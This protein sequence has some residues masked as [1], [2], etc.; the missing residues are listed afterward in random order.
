[1][2]SEEFLSAMGEI[3]EK[4]TSGAASAYYGPANPAGHEV[5]R[6]LLIAAVIILGLCAAMAGSLFLAS[7]AGLLPADRP[8][9]SGETSEAVTYPSDSTD[10][11][12]DFN[13]LFTWR[14]PVD[15]IRYVWCREWAGTFVLFLNNDGTFSQSSGYAASNLEWGTWKKED[16]I[17]TLT[18]KEYTTMKGTKRQNVYRFAEEDD[19][20]LTF[21]SEGSD[22]FGYVSVEDGDKFFP[23]GG[24]GSL[25]SSEEINALREQSR[26]EFRAVIEKNGGRYTAEDGKTEKL[27]KTSGIHFLDD[28]TDYTFHDRTPAIAESSTDFRLIIFH[29]GERTT[30]LFYLKDG[31]VRSLVG[32]IVYPYS[33]DIWDYDRNGRNDLVIRYLDRDY[34]WIITVVDLND[35]SLKT[36]QTSDAFSGTTELSNPCA[37]VFRGDLFIDG[38]KVTWNGE[39]FDGVPARYR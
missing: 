4:L 2:K 20:I 18:G 10:I 1:M 38:E 37:V 28:G 13:A 15:G 17:V 39:G 19:G 9:E 7:R 6:S 29:T 11:L 21:I 33:C 31:A 8:A 14:E 27:E 32:E 16:G 3:D 23:S 34:R 22:K 26:D 35:F 30:R 5:R 12:P 36:V 25:S 24:G